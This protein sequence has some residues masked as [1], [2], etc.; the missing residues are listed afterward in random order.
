MPAVGTNT[1]YG[2]VQRVECCAAVR[3]RRPVVEESVG[4][5]GRGVVVRKVAVGGV[6]AYCIADGYE[7]SVGKVYGAH[8]FIHPAL[9]ADNHG[10]VLV[11]VHILYRRWTFGSRRGCFFVHRL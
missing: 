5:N 7:R 10:A 8:V 3:R 11:A 4:G 6:V 1:L 2:V 9:S